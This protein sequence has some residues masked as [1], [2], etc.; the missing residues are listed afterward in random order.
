[1]VV[2]AVVGAQSKESSKIATQPASQDELKKPKWWKSR[3]KVVGS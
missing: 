3:K 2:I 1:M